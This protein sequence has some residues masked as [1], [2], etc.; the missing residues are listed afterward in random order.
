VLS[1]EQL[2]RA[3][4]ALE[5]LRRQQA[6]TAQGLGRLQALGTTHGVESEPEARLMR[7]HDPAYNVQSVVEA[8]RALIVTHEVTTEATDNTSLQTMA[9]AVRDALGAQILNVVADAGYSNGA[10]AEALEAQ[11]ISAHVPANRAVNNQ[12]DGSVGAAPIF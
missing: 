9:E 10:Q 8:E 1:R 4:E 2:L 5:V 3:R 11:G 12:G 7:G 6:Q